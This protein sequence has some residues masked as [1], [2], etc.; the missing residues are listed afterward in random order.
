MSED[1][2]G[3]F[4]FLIIVSPVVLLIL[5]VLLLDYLETRKK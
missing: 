3:C 1:L 4:Y 2:K 5:A